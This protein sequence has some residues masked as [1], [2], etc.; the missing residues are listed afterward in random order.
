MAPLAEIAFAAA[1]VFAAMLAAYHSGSCHAQRPEPLRAD[2]RELTAARPSQESTAARKQ[3]CRQFPLSRRRLDRVRAAA[4]SSRRRPQGI[5][6]YTVRGEDRSALRHADRGPANDSERHQR[7]RR[8]SR[9][10]AGTRNRRQPPSMSNS[11]SPA[12]NRRKQIAAKVPHSDHY[13]RCRQ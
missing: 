6:I 10:A 4:P 3:P 7:T 12:C 11:Y 13:R 8:S 1:D 5:G 2:D 9:R